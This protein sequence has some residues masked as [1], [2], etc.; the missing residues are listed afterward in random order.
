MNSISDK[1][2]IL[3][4]TYNVITYWSKLYNNVINIVDYF[5]T[6]M[7]RF[8]LR[9]LLR[10]STN[11]NFLDINHIQY[12][13]IPHRDKKDMIYF[14]ELSSFVRLFK[15]FEQVVCEIVYFAHSKGLLRYNRIKNRLFL[16]NFQFI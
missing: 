11:P 2:F 10:I 16:K 6:F 3:I 8:I 9:R 14:S 5:Q 12:I 1:K 4:L 7:I 13:I 15:L